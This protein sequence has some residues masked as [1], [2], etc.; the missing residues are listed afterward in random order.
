MN[1]K[2]KLFYLILLL[3]CILYF[4]GKLYFTHFWANI[5]IQTFGINFIAQILWDKIDW[6]LLLHK[7]LGEILLDNFIVAILGP[8][9]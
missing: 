9:L 6:I 4:Y 3:K 2:T 1:V 8:G 7:F 5:V